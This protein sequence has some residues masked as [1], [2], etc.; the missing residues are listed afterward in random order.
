MS[1]TEH[2]GVVLQSLARSPETV[3]LKPRVRHPEN[4]PPFFRKRDLRFRSTEEDPALPA[5]VAHVV[6]PVLVDVHFSG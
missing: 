1:H 5:R 4:P 2:N 3:D 6:S